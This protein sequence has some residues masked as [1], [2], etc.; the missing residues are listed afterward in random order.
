MEVRSLSEDD[1]PALE[2]LLMRRPSHNL[3]HLSSLAEHGLASPSEPQGR[4][5]A[6]GAFRDGELV[7]V[8]MAL[9]G[10]GGIYHEPGDGDTLAGLAEVVMD[11][12][13]RGTLSLLSSHASQAEPLLPLIQ[14]SSAGLGATA[15]MDRCFFRMLYPDDLNLPGM[16]PGFGAPRLAVEGDMERLIDFYEVGFYSLAH[17][18]TRAAWRNRLSEQLAFRTLFLIE[19]GQGGVASAALSSAEGGNGAM[20]GGVATLDKYRGKGLS[21]L[22]VGALCAYLFG[23]GLES[24]S[25]FYLQHND[26]AGRVYDKLGFTTAGEWLLVPLGLGVSFSPVFGIAD[27]TR[28]T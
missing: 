3:F 6:I 4:P 13:S 1:V 23:S 8:V 24:I 15:A 19:D 21:A 11:R 22:C 26:P 10:T 9:R 14:G 25:L 28:E 16:V 12:A 18:P 17:L 5:W 20:L 2:A 7:G 27:R